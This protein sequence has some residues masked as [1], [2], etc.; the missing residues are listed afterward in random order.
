M[1]AL[2]IDTSTFAIGL[3][4]V[5]DQEVLYSSYS[6]NGG[7]SADRIHTV[8]QEALKEAGLTFEDIDVYTC[9]IGPGSFTGIRVGLAT[10]KG[11]S[12]SLS[13]PLY[14][15]PTFDPLICRFKDCFEQ[16]VPMLDAK[17]GMV[18]AAVYRGNNQ[19]I[20]TG[21]IEIGVLTQEI[22]GDAL[23]LGNGA[24]VHRDLLLNRL[25]PRAYILTPNIDSP[26]GEDVAYQG[27][28]LSKRGE[29][30]VDPIEPIYI[31]PVMIRKK[32]KS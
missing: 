1:I 21:K 9:T 28:I 17:R 20:P 18:Y 14:G 30:P 10:I 32:V 7:P 15:I 5:E 19:V 16:I 26:R 13:K 27:L 24:R 12:L 22:E 6:N 31:E 11:L 23:F 4:I 3:G 25:G 29:T 8:I 2:G